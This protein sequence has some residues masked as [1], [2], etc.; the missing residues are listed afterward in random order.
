[1]RPEGM[2]HRMKNGEAI[3]SAAKALAREISIGIKAELAGMRTAAGKVRE[4]YQ[5]GTLVRSVK[6]TVEKEKAA[7][8]VVLSAQMETIGKEVQRIREQL[9][10]Q[11]KEK[12]AAEETAPAAKTSECE[13]EETTPVSQR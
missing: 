12:A 7:A 10:R 2:I 11:K 6:Q 5:D 1:M 13:E 8:E 9:D 3:R 4:I